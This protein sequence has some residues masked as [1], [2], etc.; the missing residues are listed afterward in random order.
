MAYF[1]FCL[2]FG[3]H[4]VLPYDLPSIAFFSAGLWAIMGRK[5]VLLCILVAVATVNRETS[6]FI[7][8]MYYLYNR[9]SRFASLGPAAVLLFEYAA[10]KTCLI[11]A[12]RHNPLPQGGVLSGL[13]VMKLVPNA[14]YLINVTRWPALLSVFGFTLPVFW[15][16]F[17]YMPDRGLQQVRWIL[18]LWFAAMMVC[19][20]IIEIRIFAE[21]IPYMATSV[22]CIVWG[23]WNRR[24]DLSYER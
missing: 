9:R 1:H 12:F 11:V 14:K 16:A 7:V 15:S 6:I 5:T 17:R 2:F 4:Y 23:L 20:V 3:P 24:V 10:I 8:V 19:G 22:A 21:L 13:F 18:P